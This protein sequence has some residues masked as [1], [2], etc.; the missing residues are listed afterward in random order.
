MPQPG[1][2]TSLV[3]RPI[4]LIMAEDSEEKLEV[5]IKLHQQFKHPSWEPAEV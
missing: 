5:E 4:V 1:A 2:L 3:F